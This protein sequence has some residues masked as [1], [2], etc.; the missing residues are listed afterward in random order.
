MRWMAVAGACGCALVLAGCRTT[1]DQC[2]EIVDQLCERIHE[3]ESDANKAETLWQARFGSNVEDC[4]TELYENPLQPSQQTGIA[5]DQADT[6]QKLCSN[7]GHTFARVFDEAQAD[8]CQRAR[9]ALSCT[10]YLAQFNN[11]AIVPAACGERCRAE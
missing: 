3:C 1:Q 5:C 7:L 2:R 9:A 8:E 11:P 6:V 4:K 10:D